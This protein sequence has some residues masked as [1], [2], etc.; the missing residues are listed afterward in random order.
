MKEKFIKIINE[1]NKGLIERESQVKLGLLAIV[2]GENILFIGPPG[3]AKSKI[4]RRL[5]HILKKSSYFEYLLTK[6]TT[7]EEIF[8]PISLK[9]L[10]NDR[11]HRNT[12]GYLTDSNVVFLDEIFKANSAI[13]NSLLTIL[14]EKIYHNGYIKENVNTQLIIGASN[15]LPLNENDLEA[16]YDRFLFRNYLNY[17]KDTKSLFKLT[18][19][20]EVFIEDNLKF[21]LLELNE[22]NLKIDEVSIS[23]MIIDKI[24]KI[25]EELYLE[26]KD[27]SYLSDRRIVKIVKILKIMALTTDRKNISI[28]DLLILNYIIWKNE[29]DIPKI[30]EIIKDVVLNIENYNIKD[31]EL[32]LNKWESHFND[33][34]KEQKKDS[35]GNLL[36]WDINGDIT[37][38]KKGDVHVKD[39]INNYVFFKGYRDYIKISVELGKFDH[40]YIDTGIRTL[41]KKI[42]WKYEYS[43]VEVV[44]NFDESLEGFDKLTVNGNLEPIYFDNFKEYYEYF[45]KTKVEHILI[46]KEIYRNISDEKIKISR[47]LNSLKEKEKFILEENSDIFWLPFEAINDIKNDIIEKVKSVEKLLNNYNDFI[48]IVKVASNE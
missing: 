23:E 41:D 8:G 38:E 17:V 12:K 21:E 22:I 37:L 25:R 40:G 26:F 34:F 10:E 5:S 4:G 13:L 20:D 35:E 16:L 27:S 43:P 7:P 46:F 32:F 47:L 33:F 24:I 29:E 19:N 36:Y 30:R 2:S 6:F 9:E 3:T 28:F 15:E 31:F 18:F 48:E 42:I 44:T 45:G 14:N 1:L 11:F 39:S